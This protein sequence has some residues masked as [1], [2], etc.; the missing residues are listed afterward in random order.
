MGANKTNTAIERA[1]RSTGGE[2]KIL[3]NFDQKV[4]KAK[5]S[6]AHTHSSSALGESK[7]LADLREVK[8]FAYHGNRRFDS[9]PNISYDP[10]ESLDQE[11][12]Q[13]WLGRHKRNLLLNAPQAQDE[14]EEE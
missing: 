6:S 2:R 7:I 5:K 3:E 1:S 14:D 12:F 4:R 13:R 8:P 10:L 9:F 11:D